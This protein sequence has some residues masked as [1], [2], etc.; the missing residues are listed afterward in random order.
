MN[1]ENT[2]YMKI[3]DGPTKMDDDAKTKVSSSEDSV[4]VAET[5][6]VPQERKGFFGWFYSLFVRFDP[7]AVAFFMTSYANLGFVVFFQLM[8]KDYFKHYLLLGPSDL[9]MTMSMLFIPWSFKVV[10]GLMS[11]TIPIAGYK[12]RSYMMLNGLTGFICLQVIGGGF[13][14]GNQGLIVTLFVVFMGTYAFND[15]LADSLICQESKKDLERGAEDLQSLTLGMVATC[16]MISGVLGA[17]TTEYLN[18]QWGLWCYSFFSL[19]LAIAAYFTSEDKVLEDTTR[20]EH[21]KE[22]IGLLGGACKN[23]FIY[24]TCLFY[25]FSAAVVPRFPEYKYYYMLN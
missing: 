16:G 14:D 10:Y 11:D 2:V 13:A 4:K 6:Q 12:R 22:Q 20:W 15:V 17:Y 7:A 18:P 23:S 3:D 25:I 21:F 1:S 5:I 19:I 9:Q 8:L 24:K